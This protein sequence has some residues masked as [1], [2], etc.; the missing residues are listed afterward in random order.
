M[1]FKSHPSSFLRQHIHFRRCYIAN[2]PLLITHSLTLSYYHSLTS[3]RPRLPLC[4]PLLPS[5]PLPLV[6]LS[7]CDCATDQ[8]RR[9]IRGHWG[10]M[11]GSEHLLTSIG[12]LL[13]AL[14][15]TMMSHNSIILTVKRGM[16]NTQVLIGFNFIK[17]FYS[18]YF[19]R[20]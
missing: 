14:I 17:N 13:V 15:V 1:D 2:L 6:N 5:P 20:N 12:L 10:C 3:Y 11:V 4:L 7:N 18:F 16:L 8:T 19:W 9:R